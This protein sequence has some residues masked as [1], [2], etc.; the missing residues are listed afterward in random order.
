MAL[1]SGIDAVYDASTA[2][3][4]AGLGALRGLLSSIFYQVDILSR[5][6]LACQVVYRRQGSATFDAMALFDMCVFSKISFL[7][8]GMMAHHAVLDMRL[9]I[10]RRVVLVLLHASFNLTFDTPIPELLLSLLLIELP[11][12]RLELWRGWHVLV[13][14][15]A[16][17]SLVAL[18]LRLVLAFLWLCLLVGRLAT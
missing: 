10:L 12:R 16:L 9:P 11:L 13:L 14:L 8:S 3:A 5:S 17:I 1:I 7:E 4:F 6:S 2:T 18:C 15:L